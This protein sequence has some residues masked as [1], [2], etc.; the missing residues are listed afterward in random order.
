MSQSTT[1]QTTLIQESDIKRF[2]YDAFKAVNVNE[3]IAELTAHALWLT[4]LRG[5]DSHGIRLLPHYVVAVEGGRINPQPNIQF[6]QTALATGILDA[7]HTLGHAASTLAMRHAIDIAQNTGIGI[8]VAKN[9]SHNGAQACYGLQAAHQD[10]IG[11]VMTSASAYVRTPNSTR[12]F[13]GTNPICF[14]APMLTEAPFCYDAA[15]TPF[16]GNKLIQYREDEKTLPEGIAADKDGHPTTDAELAFQLIPIGDYKG[17][18]LLILVDMLSSML[19]GMPSGDTIST[20]FDK[21]LS[22]KRYLAHFFMAIRIDA[23]RNIDQFKQ[24][25]QN[26]ADKIRNQPRMKEHVPVMVP[27]DPEKA[28]RQYRTQ[29]GIP[30]KPY[31]LQRFIKLATRLKITP[32]QAM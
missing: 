7:D 25:L 18:G 1:P 12:P 28:M 14:T 22:N 9:S 30:V 6:N 15:P 13:F 20:M 23:F 17:F 4:S 10:M 29:H 21:P 5:V 11:I 19:S 32:P 2:A 24:D 3:Q 26:N 8:V 16:T 27:G 31:D